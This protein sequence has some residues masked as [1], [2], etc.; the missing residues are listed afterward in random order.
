LSQEY[1][2]DQP[3]SSER[4]YPVFAPSAPSG[5]RH[6]RAAR[7]QH[8]VAGDDLKNWNSIAPIFWRAAAAGWVPSLGL[9][10]LLTHVRPSERVVVPAA[11]G[12]GPHAIQ[13][14]APLSYRNEP[15]RPSAA[16]PAIS[17]IW[18]SIAHFTLNALS[19]AYGSG[20]SVDVAYPA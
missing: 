14:A 18:D 3:P 5:H 1:D 7:N 10:S 20:L 15:A 11:H 8:C 17:S 2:C 12:Y 13:G 19:Y 6:D 9:K 16:R 4:G